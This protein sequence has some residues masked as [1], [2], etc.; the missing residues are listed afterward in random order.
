MRKPTITR[1]DA[2]L[3]WQGYL[4]SVSYA[5]RF[6]QFNHGILSGAVRHLPILYRWAPG[7]MKSN[8]RY[9]FH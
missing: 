5:L 7:M 4:R 6:E 1:L 8:W 2:S 3:F 9:F